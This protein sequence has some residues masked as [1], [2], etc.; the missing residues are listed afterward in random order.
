MINDSDYFHK[1]VSLAAAKAAQSD[2]WVLI[3]LDCEDDCP[4]NLGPSLLARARSVRNDVDYVVALAYREYESWFLT[5]AVSLRG[6]R[7]L[8]D[9]LEVPAN[10]DAIRDAKGWLRERMSEAYD[11]V[12][13]QLEFTRAFN[14]R[15][16]R[17]SRSF[18]RLYRKIAKMLG[19]RI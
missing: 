17:A 10:V 14:L 8:P 1:Q 3:L 5:A 6:K 7:G 12:L 4:R 18:D 15:Q 11:P 2:G 9:D 13:H 19:G 16:A